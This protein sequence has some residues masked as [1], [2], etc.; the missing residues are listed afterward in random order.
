MHKLCA[1]HS[2]LKL[3][4]I[5]RMDAHQLGVLIEAGETFTVEFKRA[6]PL[7]VLSDRDIVEAVVCLAN[8]RGGYL[9]LGV[10]DD[11]SITGAAPRHEGRTDPFRLMAAI[12][13]LTDPNWSTEIELVASQGKEI[14]VIHVPEATTGPVGTSGG[15]YKRRTIQ[16][17]G[18]PGCVPYRPSEMISAGLDLSGTDYAT[19]RARGATMDDLEPAEFDRLRRLASTSR[20]DAALASLSNE[21]ILRALRLDLGRDG[22]T[23]PSLGAILLFGTKEALER[24]VPT[25]ECLFQDFRDPEVGAND[26]LRLPLFAAAEALEERIRLR[27]T[28]TEM[29]MG[30]QRIDIPM[31]A[32]T[33]AREVLA[34]ALVHRSYADLGPVTVQFTEDA[35][36]VASP[37]GFPAGVTLDNLLEQSRPRSVALADAF[38]RAGLVDRRGKGIN[39]MFATQLRAGRDVPDYSKSTN[40][41]VVATIPTGRSDL[42]LVRF[43]LNYE[44]SIQQSLKL[45]D[46]RLIHHLRSVGSSTASEL[47]DDLHL[48]MGTARALANRLVERGLVEPRGSGR[49]RRFH[50]AAG[51]FEAARDRN[52]YVRVAGVDELKQ[53]QMILEFVR[54]FGRINRSEAASLIQVSPEA[55][56]RLLRDMRTRELLDMVGQR[57]GAHYV[58]TS[59]EPHTQRSR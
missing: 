29:I 7:N 43:V 57:R 48:T 11:K 10:D 9:L 55:A 39:E 44:D 50:L 52:A 2:S 58:L 38:K 16:T 28:S 24:W 42:D 46:L 19:L 41:S 30:M 13:N 23:E 27:N 18:T 22:V 32:S 3:C 12:L 40:A 35:L 4:I 47:A 14:I 8:G 33:A 54:R 1:H 6:T 15:V 56:S 53:E 5:V 45:D 34:N 51:F 20:G 59:S 37:G 26:S 21:D 25:A 31:I 17:D 36:T 49:H